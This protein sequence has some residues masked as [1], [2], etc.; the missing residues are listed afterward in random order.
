MFPHWLLTQI[1]RFTSRNKLSILIYHQVFAQKDPM[2]P[3]EPDADEFRWQMQ[4]ISQYFNPLPL[5]EAVNLLKQGKLPANSICVTFDDG[6]LNNL[7][8]AQPI[9]QEFAIP[10]TVYIATGFSQGCN[11]WNDRLID[12]IGHQQLN[13]VNLSALSMPE[14]SVSDWQSRRKLVSELIP[15]IKYQDYQTRQQTVDKLYQDNHVAEQKRKMMTPD[16]V[17]QLHQKGVDI[18]AHTVD[19]PIL[20]AQTVEQQRQ[21]INDSKQLIEQWL[22]HPISGFAYPNGK[23]DT[24]YNSDSVEQ[25]KLANFQYAVATDWGVST[26]TTHHLELKR[27]TPWDRND[28][29]FHLR[30]IRNIIGI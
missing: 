23:S 16:E 20:T 27:F 4:L 19:H 5:T 1:G 15:K 13:K 11:M 2:R 28:K 7:Q 3:S 21:Q 6:Y 22:G 18:G 12:L 9:L 30:L 24:D 8:I 26:P 17:I 29:K 14:V 10:A 25:V